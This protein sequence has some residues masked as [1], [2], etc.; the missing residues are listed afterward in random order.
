METWEQL[1]VAE[2]DELKIIIL[3]HRP[4]HTTFSV[5]VP[6]L[7]IHLFIKLG[8]RRHQLKTIP[9]SAETLIFN[10]VDSIRSNIDRTGSCLQITN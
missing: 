9:T 7:T 10:N 4:R 2:V 8:R 5:G 3:I 1:G 6:Q